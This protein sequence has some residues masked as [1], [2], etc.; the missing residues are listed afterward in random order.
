HLA[1]D[2]GQDLLRE[3]RIEIG[4]I[5]QT[6]QTGDLLLLALRVGS[7]HLVGSLERAHRLGAAETLGQNMNE[8]SVQVID[9]S[10][11]LQELGSCFVHASAH[12]PLTSSSA[13]RG[14]RY[15]EGPEDRA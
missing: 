13:D 12:F 7:W 3:I 4:F 5:S 15:P 2:E 14:T 1:G 11:I 10:P 8:C 6:P 9:G